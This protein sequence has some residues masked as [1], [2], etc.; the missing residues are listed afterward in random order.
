M[1]ILAVLS[2]VIIAN[3]SFSILYFI[4]LKNSSPA[5]K[6][7]FFE[8][9]LSKENI[10]LSTYIS[11]LMTAIII[12]VSFI[13]RILLSSGGKA[14]AESLNG[15][16]ISTDTKDFK[17]RQLL[18]IVEEMAIASGITVPPTYI[19]N[20]ESINAF[21][22]GYNFSD[23]VIGVTK[24][25]LNH[26]NRDELQAVIAHEFSHIFN[27][28]MKLNIKLIS[29]LHGILFIT[30]IGRSLLRSAIY[31]STFSRSRNNKNNSTL[32]I[33]I[34]LT[35]TGYIGYIF[36]QIIKASISRQREYLADASAVQFT[37]NKDGIASALK[38]IGTLSYGSEIKNPKSQE[39]S[40]M[41]FGESSSNFLSMMAT[42]PPLKD[43]ILAIDPNWDKKFNS[44]LENNQKKTIEAKKDNS[45]KKE[46]I[47]MSSMAILLNN[48]GNIKKENINKAH[49]IISNI[50][51]KIREEMYNSF[52]ARAVIYSLLLKKD[53]HFTKQLEI[54]KINADNQVLLLLKKIYPIINKID[55]SSILSL[56]ELSIPAL[57]QL[58]TRQ[59]INFK[60]NI[61]LLVNAD[62][63]I[64]LFE[65][66]LSKIIFHNLDIEFDPKNIN[67]KER[68]GIKSLKNEINLLLSLISY[69]DKNNN[70]KKY[71]DLM[72]KS[73]KLIK[74]SLINNK[75]IKISDL[76]KSIIKL[77][78]LKLSDKEKLFKMISNYIDYDEKSFKNMELIRAISVI[79]DCPIALS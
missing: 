56:I 13:K 15:I 6:I 4:N 29:V 12:I 46:N 11:L 20:E 77:E 74:F 8:F 25:T 63:K 7:S 10:T 1:F 30:I 50:P 54:L 58:S 75:N 37:R 66:S 79:L 68:Y 31:R 26:L 16:L 48:I 19:I 32:I 18:N 47:K 42:H 78:R 73:E 21:A 34:I 43:R 62:Y 76:D 24:G 61:N 65:W 5:I 59:Y 35:I 67:N 49:N 36:G 71:F 69:N 70:P 60:N 28:D 14:V 17:E 39:T 9:L 55:K 22:A 51:D 52:G 3:L 2:V 23:A 45:N 53:Q 57:K 72:T 33:G 44:N 27:G 38:K 41:F 64:S 40:H